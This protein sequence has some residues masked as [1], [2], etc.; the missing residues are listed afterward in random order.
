VQRETMAI[1]GQ[2]RP[3]MKYLLR[4]GWVW[5]TDPANMDGSW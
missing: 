3:Q 2:W 1:R 5:K 4:L